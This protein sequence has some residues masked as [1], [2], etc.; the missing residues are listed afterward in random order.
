MLPTSFNNYFIRL[1]NSS[2]AKGVE[3]YSPP[4][5]LKK[6]REKSAFSAL[7]RF[8]CSDRGL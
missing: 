3:G 6:K 7:T 2:V 8:V 1:D 4:I 5:G